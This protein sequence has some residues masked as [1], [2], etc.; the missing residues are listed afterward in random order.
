M[1]VPKKRLTAARQG[2][3]RSHLALRAVSLTVCTNC[4]KPVRP[5]QMC[6]ACG[7][8]RGAKVKA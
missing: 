6:V 4:G 3:R 8:Y 5:H 2:R 7:F 1:A